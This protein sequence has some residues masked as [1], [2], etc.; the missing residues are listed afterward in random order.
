VWLDVKDAL[1]QK[2]F[3][4]KDQYQKKVF[5]IADN[6]G[7]YLIQKK[8]NLLG[9]GIVL[10]IDLDSFSFKNRAAQ[11]ILS[12]T[13]REAF[14]TSL[15]SE[16]KT[17]YIAHSTDVEM[18]KHLY[19]LFF[20]QSNSHSVKD[21]LARFEIFIEDYED[22]IE[23][24]ISDQRFENIKK[25]IINNLENPYKNLQ[26]MSSTLN[27]IAF[28]KEKDFL[29]YEKRI[30]AMQKLT[31]P[32]FISFCKKTLS[33]DNKKRLAVLFEGK[34]DKDFKYKKLENEEH[35]TVGYYKTDDIESIQ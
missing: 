5:V 31:Y 22:N 8:I 23:E 33:K 13:L 18:Q 17:A 2:P 20:V 24:K 4:P 25:S 19:Q 3:L 27:N 29:W 21:L 32:E 34:L 7:P 15:R 11:N 9:N 1:R 30:E 26:E 6:N 28:E 35:K 16:Q 12:Q 14:F 10:A